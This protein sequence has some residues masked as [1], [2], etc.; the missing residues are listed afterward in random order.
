MAV[1]P[2]ALTNVGK[3]VDTTAL[4][5]SPLTADEPVELNVFVAA[6]PL[7]NS[8]TKSVIQAPRLETV[9]DEMVRMS[10]LPVAGGVTVHPG[11]ELIVSVD[12]LPSGN[13]VT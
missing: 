10:P 6:D 4:M 13:R 1:V 11:I 3:I 9:V 8:V 5:V 7:A 12:E 2:D